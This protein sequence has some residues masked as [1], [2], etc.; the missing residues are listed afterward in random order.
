MTLSKGVQNETS[1]LAQSNCVFIAISWNRWLMCNSMISMGGPIHDEGEGGQQCLKITL[2]SSFRS[3]NIGVIWLFRELCCLCKLSSLALR[4]W[5]IQRKYAYVV[6]FSAIRPSS[7]KIAFCVALFHIS[8]VP[9]W[10]CGR[11]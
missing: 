4:P 7:M 10:R 11:N 1:I 3:N 5:V 9:K 2:R 8:M 6:I